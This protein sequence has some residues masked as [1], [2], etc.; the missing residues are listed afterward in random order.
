VEHTEAQKK[1]EEIEESSM[2]DIV[3]TLAL[4]PTARPGPAQE[5][6]PTHPAG[7]TA[8]SAP[9]ANLPGWWEIAVPSPPQYRWQAQILA[10]RSLDRVKEDSQKVMREFS[11]QLQDLT[12]VIMQTR[13]GDAR[14]EFYR[15]RVLD[16][17]TLQAATAWCAEIRTRGR[18]CLVTRVSP[19]NR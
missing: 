6:E 14:D 16:F 13:Y 7:N 8:A 10:G 11:S 1:G 15:L 2:L 3:D 5:Y 4:P 18:D 17:P 9:P 12:L 19:V